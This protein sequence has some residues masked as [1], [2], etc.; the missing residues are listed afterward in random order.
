MYS[1]LDLDCNR[2]TSQ[3][4]HLVSSV[5]GRAL[6]LC[7]DILVG[8]HFSVALPLELRQWS[9]RFLP[10]RTVAFHLFHLVIGSLGSDPSNADSSYGF[11]KSQAVVA[12]IDC[13]SHLDLF[14]LML[15]LVFIGLSYLVF[16]SAASFLNPLLI[17]S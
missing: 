10:W 14:Y 5:L 6:G 7:K 8:I 17:H 13:S 15:F 1:A 3:D 2:R 11:A 4:A 9:K 12:N 16:L